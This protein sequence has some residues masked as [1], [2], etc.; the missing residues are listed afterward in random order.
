M[1]Y[2]ILALVVVSAFRIGCHPKALEKSAVAKP[3]VAIDTDLNR[4]YDPDPQTGDYDPFGDRFRSQL[5]FL[6]G[7][8]LAQTDVVL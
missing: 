7:Q 1:R 2:L 8:S 3:T 6:Q 4:E 5:F